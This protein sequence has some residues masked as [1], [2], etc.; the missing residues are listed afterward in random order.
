MDKIDI[1]LIRECMIKYDN[2]VVVLVPK[3]Y[4]FNRK[5]IVEYAS[6]KKLLTKGNEIYNNDEKSRQFII[7]QKSKYEEILIDNINEYTNP[8]NFYFI[9][10]DATLEFDNYDEL[11][12]YMLKK[13]YYK[14]P[15]IKSPISSERGLTNKIINTFVIPKEK[16]I[17]SNSNAEENRH[18]KDT[19]KAIGLA[20]IKEMAL[21]NI[22]A[23]LRLPTEDIDSKSTEIFNIVCNNDKDDIF[24]ILGKA[25]YGL[26]DFLIELYIGCAYSLEKI[27]VYE[28]GIPSSIKY[29]SIEKYEE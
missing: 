25:P 19:M 9:F 22:K 21:G 15:N 17:P 27:Y 12:S 6:Y 28:G 14:F 5:N 18:I 4:D 1:R 8:K 2:N 11:I 20:E 23:E 13:H 29:R 7:R 24:N 3:K 26:P 10:N 16:T